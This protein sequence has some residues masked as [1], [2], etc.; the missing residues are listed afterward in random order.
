[1]KRYSAQLSLTA[2]L[3]FLGTLKSTFVTFVTEHKASVWSIGWDMNL[4]GAAYA[5]RF[6]YKSASHLIKLRKPD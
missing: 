1:M 2:L 6:S 4:L 5:V 3:V